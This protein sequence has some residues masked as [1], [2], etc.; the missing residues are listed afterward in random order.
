M[1]LTSGD[2]PTAAAE[3]LYYERHRTPFE[4]LRILVRVLTGRLLT[5]LSGAAHEAS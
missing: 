2:Q 5:R 3:A 4:D 1:R